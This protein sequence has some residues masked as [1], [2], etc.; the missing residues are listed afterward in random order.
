VEYSKDYTQCI[1]DS[2]G[3]CTIKIATNKTIPAPV[4]F[5]YQIDNFFMN[6]RD[7]VKSRSYPQLRGDI[8]IDSSNNSIC[9]G[10]QYVNEIFNNDS[11]RYKSWAGKPLKGNDYANPCGLIAKSIFNDTNFKITNSKDK[12]FYIDDSDIANN[13]DVEFM[14]KK[15]KDSETLQWTNVEDRKFILFLFR[16]F[17][18]MDANGILSK[19]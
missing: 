1:N 17:Y 6:H 14:F 12:V 3:Y 8:H 4:Y 7:F 2:E 13:F 19:F 16:A 18:R 9:K 10:A 11:S 15:H 5:Y